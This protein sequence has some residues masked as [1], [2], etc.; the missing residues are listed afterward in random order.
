MGVN[1]DLFLKTSSVF[2]LT[3]AFFGNKFNPGGS[4]WSRELSEG[5]GKKRKKEE[6]SPLLSLRDMRERD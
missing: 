6:G 5:G 4:R 3:E 2:L 1:I